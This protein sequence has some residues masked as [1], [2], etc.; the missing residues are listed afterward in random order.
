[1]SIFAELPDG[2]RLEFP[3]GT[4]Q[5]VIDRTVK[6][7]IA[8]ARN[9]GI[10]GRLMQT[11]VD[12]GR[13]AI[14][15]VAEG[16]LDVTLRAPEGVGQLGDLVGRGVMWATGDPRTYEQARLDR[17]RLVAGDATKP[18]ELPLLGRAAYETAQAY[19]EVS[20]LASMA[21]DRLGLSYAP[22]TTPGR[23]A[24]AMTRFATGMAFP[25]TLSR[26]L[27][28]PLSPSREAGIGALT[29][30]TSE[31]G[32]DIA[33]GV[34]ADRAWGQVAGAL[35]TPLGAATL[36]TR[37]RRN[38]TDVARDVLNDL[39]PAEIQ[40]AIASQESA[41]R[42]GTTLFPGEAVPELRQL[43]G[44]TM[45]QGGEGATNLRR[46]YM[47]RDAASQGVADALMPDAP[48]PGRPAL[49]QQLSERARQVGQRSEMER[50]GATTGYGLAGNNPVDLAAMDQI[51]AAARAEA[52]RVGDTTSRG[53]A[54]LAI[55][56]SFRDSAGN[57]YTTIEQWHSRYQDL[58][59]ALSTDLGQGQ[60][61]LLDNLD[62][63]VAAVV[64]PYLSQIKDVLRRDPDF[65]QADDIYQR[66]SP[67]IKALF[68]GA[69]LPNLASLETINSLMKLESWPQVRQIMLGE[70]LDPSSLRDVLAR[71][72]A[73]DA[74]YSRIDPNHQP[75]LP[76]VAR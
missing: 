17:A 58:R 41:R 5:D 42:L 48:F 33:E 63:S 47:E 31:A 32:G 10:A 61:R 71:V 19:G 44:D 59:N 43:E 50:T 36:G 52:Q 2:T 14:S 72:N 16:A 13:G 62:K 4:S 15:G 64:E 6:K 53:K 40:A 20:D 29:G 11:N 1:M 57:P 27:G 45:A 60:V 39:P 26:R 76:L 75:I 54:L 34:G 7:H 21:L 68:G 56:D 28:V 38:A 69:E 51:I 23:Y 37:F 74:Q 67:E 12:I 49:V 8:D 9:P 65:Q 25:A 55:A 46:A 3:D 66:M 70:N 30:L 22:E 24:Q 18:E 73:E 35:L